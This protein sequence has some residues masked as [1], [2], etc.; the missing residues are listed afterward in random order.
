V[1]VFYIL[2]GVLAAWAVLVTAL[3]VTNHNF[4]GSRERLVSGISILLVVAAIA[5]AIISS[6]NEDHGGGE[7][8]E[9]SAALGR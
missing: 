1:E 8:G 9:E 2:G 5:A 6:A 7:H 3:G 4:P